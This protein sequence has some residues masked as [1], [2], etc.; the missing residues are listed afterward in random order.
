MRQASLS[1]KQ[2]KD[3][4]KALTRKIRVKKAILKTQEEEEAKAQLKEQIKHELAELDRLLPGSSFRLSMEDNLSR[5]FQPLKFFAYLIT[6]TLS[7]A[8]F[9]VSIAAYL[10]WLALTFTRKILGFFINLLT[11]QRYNGRIE[12]YKTAQLPQ[13]FSQAMDT[14]KRQNPRELG[15]LETDED[16]F[17]TSGQVEFYRQLAAMQKTFSV[18]KEVKPEEITDEE[19]KECY[20]D[21]LKRGISISPLAYAQCAFG[22]LGYA[23][24][25]PPRGSIARLF[26]VLTW[27]PRLALGFVFC[28]AV[29]L[30]ETL[31]LIV[32]T[33]LVVTTE[34]LS[35]IVGASVLFAL[36]LPL[37]L[38][39]DIPRT[40][41]ESLAEDKQ[42][43]AMR[44]EPKPERSP[45][46][47]SK[48]LGSSGRSPLS[49]AETRRQTE[50]AARENLTRGSTPGSL[51]KNTSTDR[52]APT[53]SSSRTAPTL[54]STVDADAMD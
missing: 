21:V 38:F 52:P 50:P 9:L 34:A 28:T 2:W 5:Y 20:N 3:D 4:I 24:T 6:R 42:K 8:L 19:V 10:P 11:G 49:T 29:T 44:M 41:A 22:A 23:L 32:T 39:V 37:Y 14:L 31:K 13:A 36:N 7:F 15:R 1:P 53:S 51:P 33:T 25:H 47:N 46:V 27:L 43:S 17:V 18:K 30:L 54:A 26:W 45:P 16:V 48:D 12:A 40:I 35:Y